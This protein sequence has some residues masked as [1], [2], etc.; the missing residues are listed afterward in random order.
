MKLRL[1]P[2]KY[3]GRLFNTTTRLY[4]NAVWWCWRQVSHPSQNKSA[5][6]SSLFIEAVPSHPKSTDS[7]WRH[8]RIPQ[9]H[10]EP[11]QPPQIHRHQ[12]LCPQGRWRRLFVPAPAVHQGAT[13]LHFQHLQLKTGGTALKRVYALL[14]LKTSFKKTKDTQ[15]KWMWLVESFKSSLF[16]VCLVHMKAVRVIGYRRHYFIPQVLFRNKLVC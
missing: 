1:S 2:R 5:S 9:N 14:W 6:F 13:H 15:L 16:F 4:C 3:V 7:G 11:G 12:G 10:H 8:L